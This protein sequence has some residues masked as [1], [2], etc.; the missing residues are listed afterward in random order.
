MLSNAGESDGPL[1]QFPDGPQNTGGNPVL[2][3]L[4]L[5]VLPWRAKRGTNTNIKKGIVVFLFVIYLVISLL[6]LLGVFGN[7]DKCQSK[8]KTT[9]DS[10]D[11]ITD[12][13]T[14]NENVQCRMVSPA[15][16]LAGVGAVFGLFA[17]FM[18]LSMVHIFT[19][20]GNIRSGLYGVFGVVPIFLFVFL[21]MAFR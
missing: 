3:Y 18:L 21:P 4:Q 15:G 13:K 6:A 14:C 11:K 2:D 1:I 20:R 5:L 17:W 12:K 19:Q 7:V 16:P 10:C 9:D 8:T